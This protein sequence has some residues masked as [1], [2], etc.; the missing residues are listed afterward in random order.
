MMASRAAAM[1]SRAARRRAALFCSGDAL[2]EM[3]SCGNLRRAEIGFLRFSPN[4][5]T[6][7]FAR[8]RHESSGAINQAYGYVVESKARKTRA[9]V[10][11]GMESKIL[12]GKSQQETLKATTKTTT[13]IQ[14]LSSRRACSATTES[15]TARRSANNEDPRTASPR[16]DGS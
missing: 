9:G 7:V 16:R 3:W 11:E 4:A 8:L 10:R 12:R 14:E 15:I 1:A 13:I 2:S 5:V 6:I